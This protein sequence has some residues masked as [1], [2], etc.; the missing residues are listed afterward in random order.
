MEKSFTMAQRLKQLREGMGLSHEKLSK[1]LLDRYDVKISSDSLINYEVTDEN[2]AKALKNQGMC[3]KYL[4]SL[5]DFY[6]V[7]AD[8]ILG[9]TDD[10]GPEPKPRRRIAALKTG[11]NVIYVPFA[12][13]TNRGLEIGDTLAP[14]FHQPRTVVGLIDDPDGEVLRFLALVSEI[15]SPDS[16]D[17]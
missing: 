5:A 6:G 13:S 7:S 16:W 4:R 15:E 12:D 3:V 1:T 9:R 11:A 17:L 2:H 10:P 8:Y 14:K